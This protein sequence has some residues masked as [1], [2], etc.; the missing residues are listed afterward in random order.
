MQVCFNLPHTQALQQY[1]N[2]DHSKRSRKTNLLG[3][4]TSLKNSAVAK[5]QDYN[6]A[7]VKSCKSYARARSKQPHSLQLLPLTL[8]LLVQGILLP[9]NQFCKTHCT[10]PYF[11]PDPF[12]ELFYHTIKAKNTKPETIAAQAPIEATADLCCKWAP[13]KQW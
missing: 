10:I 1:R 5:A 11:W 3:M 13:Q 9:E 6:W 8:W 12:P 2:F 4:R 7:I